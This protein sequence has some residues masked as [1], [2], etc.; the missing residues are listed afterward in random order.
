M[1]YFV[2]DE[3][4]ENEINAVYKIDDIQDLE[5]NIIDAVQ[6]SKR[7]EKAKTDTHFI[8]GSL[9]GLFRFQ[10]N[11]KN[12]LTSNFQIMI[13]YLWHQNPHILLNENK[14]VCTF[15][16][17]SRWSLKTKNELENSY[18]RDNKFF[19]YEDSVGND[20][21]SFDYF[22]Q[23]YLENINIREDIL[24]EMYPTFL[25]RVIEDGSKKASQIKYQMF[26]NDKK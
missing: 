12:H 6:I 3:S 19:S 26:S 1:N 21:E 25:C 24:T 23:E 20:L 13:A 11:Q 8:C 15:L 14:R 7:L 9:F 22:L 10:E 5:E 4:R 2:I 18:K 16:K 17:G